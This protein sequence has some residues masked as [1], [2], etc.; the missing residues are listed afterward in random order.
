[1]T[2]ESTNTPIAIVTGAGSGVGR[3][4]AA[5]LAEAGYGVVLVGRTQSKLEQTAEMLRQDLGDQITVDIQ[6]CDIANAQSVQAM[7]ESV[8]GRFGRVDALCNVAGFAP[9]GPIAKS[10]PVTIQSCIDTNLTSVILLTS[11]LWPTFTKQDASV[12]VNVSSMASIDPF[13]GFSIY[14]AAKVGVNMYTQCTAQEGSKI[15]L[16]AIAIAPGAIETSMLRDNFSEK[17]IPANKTLDPL[18]VA[19]L[20]RDCVMGRQ[21]FENGCTVE[22]PSP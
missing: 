12:V 18:H 13:P 15:G 5:L 22:L 19:A 1:M 10:D 20:I 14:A 21:S 6:P 9:L 7:V 16:R 2:D 17:M 4:T 11:M 8:V 3:D